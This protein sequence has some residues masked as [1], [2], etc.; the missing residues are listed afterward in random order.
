MA[1]VS[2]KELLESGVHFGH[3]TRRWDPKMASY[4]FTER[5]GIHIIDL[6]KTLSKLSEATEKMAEVVR[7]GGSVLFVGT[8]KQAQ[9]S[10]REAAE[11]CG[12]YYVTNRWLGGTLTN[13]ATIRKTIE[14]LRR[15]EKMEVDGTFN[16]IQKKERLKLQK[17]REKL[18]RNIGGIKNMNRLPDAMFIVDPKR[19]H[20]AVTEG[21]KMGIPIFA[22]VDTNCDPTVIDYVVPGNDDAI[23]AI[24]L[25]A[26]A[27]RDSITEALHETGRDGEIASEAAGEGGE[28]YSAGSDYVAND[29]EESASSPFQTVEPERKLSSESYQKY[30]KEYGEDPAAPAEAVAASKTETDDKEAK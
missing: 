12:Q 10:I 23:R 2:M 15:L 9:T 6:Q 17:E 22:I 24:K 14:R 27:F 13:F 30:D 19:E 16:L 29:Q 18:E 21:R 4:I 25:F 7:D 8:K 5:N 26:R 1:K 3:Q 28:F 11:E 20:I